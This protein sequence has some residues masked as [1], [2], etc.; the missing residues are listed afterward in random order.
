MWWRRGVTLI[1]RLP[2][3]QA[4]CG[5]LRWPQQ[6]AEVERA[7]IGAVFLA[8]AVVEHEILALLLVL[9]VLQ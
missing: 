2:F 7:Q 6:L 4:L 1:D 8:L 9:Q 3:A 5:A